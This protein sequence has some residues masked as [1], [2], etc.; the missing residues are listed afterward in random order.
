VLGPE[1]YLSL[2]RAVDRFWPLSGL[3]VITIAVNDFV[4]WREPVMNSPL[5]PTA[6]P[7]KISHMLQLTVA[8]RLEWQGSNQ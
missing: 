1:G 4:P 7:P 2:I 5:I 8:P 6:A 3:P